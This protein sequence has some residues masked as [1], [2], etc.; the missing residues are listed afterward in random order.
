MLKARETYQELLS[1]AQAAKLLGVSRASVCRLTRDGVIS[2]VSEHKNRERG[3]RDFS[4]KY[5][6]SEIAAVASVREAKLSVPKLANVAMRAIAAATRNE[7]RLNDIYA[8][9]GL[10]GFVLGTSPEEVQQLYIKAQA[11]LEQP[12]TPPKKELMFWAKVFYNIHEEYFPLITQQTYSQ[13]PWRVFTDLAE[14]LAVEAPVHYFHIDRE[15]ASVYGYIEAGRKNLR[16]SAYLY[17]RKIHGIVKVNK[18]FPEVRG[19]FDEEII[20]LMFL[21]AE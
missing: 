4:R 5:D 7:R 21:K 6:P 13:E 14:R 17:A 12:G 3:G 15:L 8:L 18:L 2:Y 19:G 9:L 10:D 16:S 1:E 11:A 20:R